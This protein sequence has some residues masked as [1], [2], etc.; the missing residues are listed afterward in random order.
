MQLF[1]GGLKEFWAQYKNHTSNM[2]VD[3]Q[4]KSYLFREHHFIAVLII[5]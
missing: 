1:F 3:Y 4:R 2:L 5:R